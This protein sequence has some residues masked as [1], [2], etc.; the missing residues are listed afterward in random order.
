MPWPACQ[1]DKT[2]FINNANVPH[3]YANIGSVTMWNLGER[4]RSKDFQYILHCVS[5][6]EKHQVLEDLWKQHTEEMALLEGNLLTVAGKQCTVEFQ[7]SA[8]MS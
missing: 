5:L 3:F 4:V 1:V 6:Q 7:P 2:Q 8:D